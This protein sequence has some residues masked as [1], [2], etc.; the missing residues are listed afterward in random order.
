MDPTDGGDKSGKRGSVA[1]EGRLRTKQAGR[2][3][4][5]GAPWEGRG[6]NGTDRD[7]RTGSGR[8]RR[9]DVPTD[10]SPEP[11]AG[12]VLLRGTRGCDEGVTKR[13]KGFMA[14]SSSLVKLDGTGV[15][16]TVD[17]PVRD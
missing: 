7:R 5:Y 10:E 16:W 11:E 3:K 8:D 12:P 17:G 15:Q 13:R 9:G 2:R 4:H 14:L 6:R 1:G